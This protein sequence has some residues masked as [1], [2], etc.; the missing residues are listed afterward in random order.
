M[1]AQPQ[2]TSSRIQLLLLFSMAVV[3]LG[4][5]WLL[6]QSAQGGSV[7]GT[8][9]KGTFVDPPLT[10]AEL[11]IRDSAGH[12]SVTDGTWWLWVVPQGPCEAACQEALHQMRQLHVLL[13]R[14]A[15]RVRRALMSQ[16][17]TA[18]PHLEALYP[19]LAFLSGNVQALAHGVY[20]VDP[21]GNLV[22]HYPLH[23]SERMVL[24]DLKR[25]LKV[26]QIG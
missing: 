14:D 1:T 6:F 9:N 25:L 2:R 8:T 15:K 4:G 11:Q 24:D 5:A 20:I 13:N 23:G 7:W 16:T 22:L 3:S 19:Q 12:L 18:D 26:S 10:A 17:V 21:I